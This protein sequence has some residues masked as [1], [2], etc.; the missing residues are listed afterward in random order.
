MGCDYGFPFLFWSVERHNGAAWVVPED[1]GFYCLLDSGDDR[2]LEPGEQLL[3]PVTGD[4][5]AGRYRLRAF[6]VPLGERL[7]HYRKSEA[8]NPFTVP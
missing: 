6:Y 1:P 2:V 4:W 5:A 8:S 3:V 7:D